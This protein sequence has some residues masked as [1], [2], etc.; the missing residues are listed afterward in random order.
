MPPRPKTLYDVLGVTS[1]ADKD[2]VKKAY[3]RL[4]RELHPDATRGDKVKEERFKEVALAYAVLGDQR[5]RAAYDRGIS[6]AGGATIFGARFEEFVGRVGG[7]GIT[8]DNF[9]KFMDD[10][11]EVVQEFKAESERRASGTKPE[12]LGSFIGLIED[13]FGI[14]E[15]VIKTGTEKDGPG[16]GS[17]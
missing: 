4:A 15:G 3:R 1:D 17:R 11:L 7:E 12:D 10:F 5:K 13:L 6:T 16:R 14:E 2:I 8:R 9:S